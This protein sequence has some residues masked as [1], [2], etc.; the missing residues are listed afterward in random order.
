M[1][2]IR[3]GHEMVSLP[4]NLNKDYKIKKSDL[5]DLQQLLGKKVVSGEMTA[6][7]CLSVIN[8]L[9]NKYIDRGTRHR[10]QIGMIASNCSYFAEL[11]RHCNKI[12]TQEQKSAEDLAREAAGR[13][14]AVGG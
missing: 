3:A 8:E 14:T 2:D 13:A 1:V 4:F 11:K 7:Q 5:Y 12:A 9:E 6:Q 10:A